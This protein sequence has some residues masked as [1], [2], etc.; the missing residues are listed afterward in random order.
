MAVSST[1]TY[2]EKLI[3]FIAEFGIYKMRRLVSLLK[4]YL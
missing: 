1:P 2:T 3:I 4:Q